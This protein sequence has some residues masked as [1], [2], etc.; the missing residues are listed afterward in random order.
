MSDFK[1]D[2]TSDLTNDLVPVPMPKPLKKAD[3]D[4]LPLTL[5]PLVFSDKVRRLNVNIR[6]SSFTKKR[7]KKK[8]AGIKCKSGVN[9]I[10]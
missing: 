4:D 8:T 5:I 1:T 6:R 7:K 10:Y 2:L 9:G 3:A